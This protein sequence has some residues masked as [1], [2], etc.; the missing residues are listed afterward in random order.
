[1]RYLTISVFVLVLLAACGDEDYTNPATTTAEVESNG[2]TPISNTT[3]TTASNTTS[4]TSNTVVVREPLKHRPEP[5]PCDDFRNTDLPSDI[6]EGE[7]Q[8]HEDCPDGANGRC[9]ENRGYS[10]CTY[11]QCFTDAECGDSVC[12]CG[13]D[14]GFGPNVCLNAGNCAVDSDCGV[15]GYCSPSFGDCG[16]YGGVI[17]FFCHTPEDACIDDV[18]CE[19]G[20]CAYNP[21]TGRW[22]CSNSECAG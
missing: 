19:G 4:S 17:G 2:T 18:D 22:M 1:M 11:D 7:C 5:V 8:S 12:R 15:G 3:T 9:T 10:F 16:N 20:Y 21:N 6:V 14:Q 13:D